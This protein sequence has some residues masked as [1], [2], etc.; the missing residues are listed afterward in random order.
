MF[1]KKFIPREHIQQAIDRYLAIKQDDRSVAEYIVEE[2]DMENTLG[3]W[4]GQPLKE[5]SFRKG[6]HEWIKDRLIAFREL[7]LE[8]YKKKAEYVDQDARERMVGPYKPQKPTPTTPAS[9]G[10]TSKTTTNHDYNPKNDSKKSTKPASTKKQ[11]SRNELRKE[12]RCFN[13][14]EKGHLASV[15]GIFG[16]VFGR[17]VSGFGSPKFHSF[18]ALVFPI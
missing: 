3:E 12:G 1:R 9:K 18:L 2:E 16:R 4:I 17:I 11:M 14:K 8:K 15:V 7:P 5:T 6:L 10:T 13:C